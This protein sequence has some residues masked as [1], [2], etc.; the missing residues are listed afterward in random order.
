[1]TSKALKRR[2][3]GLKNV[4][5]TAI[6]KTEAGH[7][8]AKPLLINRDLQIIGPQTLDFHRISRSARVFRS[9][10]PACPARL[11]RESAPVWVYHGQRSVLGAH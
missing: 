9:L 1:M 7:C 2:G 5:I 8:I 4:E 10:S 11:R 3:E 6:S